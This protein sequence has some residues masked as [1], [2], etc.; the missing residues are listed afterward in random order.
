MTDEEKDAERIKE[1]AATAYRQME[2]AL[3]H[4]RGARNIVATHGEHPAVQ[5]YMIEM[6]LTGKLA[7][8]L[9]RPV[10]TRG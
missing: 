4:E 5:R 2:A 6:G 10:V 3:D 7:E 8:F 1:R 9:G